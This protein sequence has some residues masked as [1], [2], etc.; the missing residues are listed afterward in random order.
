MASTSAHAAPFITGD[1]FAATGNGD[2]KHYNSSGTL[3]ETLN[4]GQ[5]GFTT[6]MGFDASGNLYVTNFS[7][8]SITRFSGATGAILPP[9]PFASPGS[10]PESLAFSAGGQFYVGRAGGA[11]QR[12]SAAGALQQTYGMAGDTDWIDLAANQTTLF[13][14]DEAGQ[15]K[16]W[17]LIT[18]TALAN[19]ADNTANGGT[20]SFA[21]RILANGDVLSAAGSRVNQYNA[22]GTFLGFYDV[23][24]VDA[25]FA[26]NIDPTGTS[27]LSGSF[28]NQTLYRFNIGGFGNNTQTQTLVAGGQLFG[29]AIA[30]EK[31]V[32][33]GGVPEPATWAMLL[34][35]F[36]GM[37]YAMRRHPK[38]TARI[39]FT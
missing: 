15:I 16:R 5:G 9:N 31:T 26:L 30:G 21:L 2:V 29:V 8:G 37:G 36:G 24:G 19:F 4:T 1:I 11:V 28:N 12:Y 20:N 32:A 38:V 7:A 27:F 17:D 35:G 25:F 14:N 34:L 10:S 39:R 33:T 3:I 6:G 18:N 13:Y 22:A 23:G